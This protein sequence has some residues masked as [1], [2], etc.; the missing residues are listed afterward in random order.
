[1]TTPK[2]EESLCPSVFGSTI[3]LSGLGEGAEGRND[4][5]RSPSF[6]LAKPFRDAGE[7]SDEFHDG[8]SVG[9]ERDTPA[10]LGTPI[11]AGEKR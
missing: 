1:M 10:P 3:R 6:P 9:L 7:G 5:A 11:A 8:G 4:G 2:R